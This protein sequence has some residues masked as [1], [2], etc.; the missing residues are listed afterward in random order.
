MT[1]PGM[2]RAPESTRREPVKLG[3]L[4]SGSG[5]NLQ[6][7]LDAIASGALHAE[8]KLVLSNK[9]GVLALERAA[10]ANVPARA[11]PH[12]DFSSREEFDRALVGALE[13]AGV[14]WI[15]LA[16]F[17]RV[18]TSEFLRA[19]GGRII[20]IHPALLPAFPGVNAIQQALDYGVKVTGCTVHYVDH[21]VDTGKIIAQ[22]AIPVLP[23]DDHDSLAARMHVAEHELFVS[24]LKEIAAGTVRPLVSSSKT[25]G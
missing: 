9:P 8:V 10:K 20:N 15:V 23:G 21:G 3:V 19:F 22:R 4:V 12:R 14:E 24:V 2:D 6:A 5:S 18:L 7:I 25:E 1:R 17:M 11:I 13:Q 16:G